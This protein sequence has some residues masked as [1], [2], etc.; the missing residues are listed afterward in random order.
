MNRV[1]R[2][3][4]CF[5]IALTLASGGPSLMTTCRASSDADVPVWLRS[6]TFSKAAQASEQLRFST[7]R[8]GTLAARLPAMAYVTHDRLRAVSI[9]PAGEEKVIH[10]AVMPGQRVHKGEVLMTYHDHALHTLY[11]QQEEAASALASANAALSEAESAFQRDL[12]LRG[13][14]VASFVSAARQEVARRVI[15][16]PGYHMARHG[17]FENL[18]SAVHRLA[19]VLPVVLILMLGLLTSALS[20]LRAALLVF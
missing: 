1:S 7:T 9:R 6:V 10:V 14:D 13:R 5:I 12:K 11:L 8:T 16:P 2:L 17:K 15:L 20:S 19:I 3:S 18:Q 4:R